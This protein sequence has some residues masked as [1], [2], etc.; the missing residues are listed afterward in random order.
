MYTLR[1]WV[2]K[3]YCH[4]SQF[5]L[6]NNKHSQNFNGLQQYI[7]FYTPRSTDWLG[8]WQLQLLRL[9]VAFRSALPKVQTGTYTKGL[10]ILEF[11]LHMQITVVKETPKSHKLL[12]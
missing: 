10:D 8:F 1:R 11:A 4:I 6:N 2:E 5:L 12:F 3:G 7:Y 9:P